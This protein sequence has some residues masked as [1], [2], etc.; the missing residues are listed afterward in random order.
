[1]DCT[2]ELTEFVVVMSLQRTLAATASTC[3]PR[4]PN[5]ASPHSCL[6]K[7]LQPFHAIKVS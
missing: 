1:M 4:P 5:C 7:A 3:A 6:V 2:S